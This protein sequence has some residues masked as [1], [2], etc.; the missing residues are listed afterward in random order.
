MQQDEIQTIQWIREKQLKFLHHFNQ[1]VNHS[2]L[3]MNGAMQQLSQY[4]YTRLQETKVMF[5][6]V[7]I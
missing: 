3:L 4:V 6:T 5:K 7:L 1:K 2:T